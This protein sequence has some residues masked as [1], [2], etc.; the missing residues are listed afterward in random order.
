MHSTGHI[1]TVLPQPQIDMLLVI[2][3]VVLH[4]TAWQSVH[5][6]FASYILLVDLMDPQ[7]MQLDLRFAT[8]S[9]FLIEVFNIISQSGDGQLF[10]V[11][12]CQY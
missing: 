3:R 4:R 12:H 5:L 7:L 10:G 2:E 11:L 9:L 6:D 8:L 1:S